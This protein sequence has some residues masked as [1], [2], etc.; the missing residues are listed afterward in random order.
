MVSF[1][2]LESA[3]GGCIQLLS[4][5]YVMRLDLGAELAAF[6]LTIRPCILRTLQIRILSSL[7]LSFLLIESWRDASTRVYVY[8][9][10]HLLSRFAVGGILSTACSTIISNQWRLIGDVRVPYLVFISSLVVSESQIALRSVESRGLI[11]LLQSKSFRIVNH[12]ASLFNRLRDLRDVLGHEVLIRNLL[13][14]K[15]ALLKLLPLLHVHQL[16]LLL[17]LQLLL[18]K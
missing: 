11:I 4:I 2:G 15:Q 12:T 13:L 8:S 7:I 16:L 3:L 18:L 5:A 10:A 1:H 9:L 6:K 17:Q 14:N